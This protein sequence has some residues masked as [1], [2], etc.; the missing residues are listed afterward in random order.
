VFPLVAAVLAACV[1]AT[2]AAGQ[3]ITVEAPT[4]RSTTAAMRL[5]QR[6]GDC[7]REVAGPWR[8]HVGRNGLSAHHR[9]GDGT[10]PAGTFGIGPTIYG[11]APSPGVRLR[12]RQ[13]RCGDWWDENPASPTYNTFRHVRCG[14][15]PAFG[16]A[17]G[18]PLWLSPRAYRHFAVVEYNAGPAEPGAGSAIFIHVDRGIPTSGCVSIARNRLV[19]LLRWLRPERAPVVAIGITGKHG[20]ELTGR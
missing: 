12:Y 17:H 18:D 13:L 11:T 5:W 8:A 16:R 14:T 7:W 2:G 9:E 3:R 15:S 6:E 1:P 19:A 20:L 4:L 10:T